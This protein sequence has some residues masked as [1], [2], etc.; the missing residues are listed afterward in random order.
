MLGH[1]FREITAGRAYRADY[2]HRA[3][4]ARKA[5]HVPGTFVKLGHPRRQVGGKA[6][7]GR[8]F[9]H[10]AGQFAESLGPAR[11]GVGH[12][13]DMV[14]LVAEIFGQRNAGVYA[15]FP[16]GDGHVG[17]VGDEHRALHEALAGARVDELGEF[18]KHVGHLVAAFAAADVHDYIG[19][20][21]FRDG[22]LSHGL[23][24]AEATGNGHRAA[25]GQR[26]QRVDDPLP[27]YER[28]RKRAAPR[29]R[30]GYAYRPAV[31]KR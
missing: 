16:R 29:H 4:A 3:F 31:K 25:F 11:G 12:D 8:H 13:G 28:Q 15:G 5:I 24:R 14:A 27:R 6:F 7:L 9:L 26:E 19:V 1:G 22:V 23:A 2:R 30:P 21:P 17:C 18:G 10:A 20:A